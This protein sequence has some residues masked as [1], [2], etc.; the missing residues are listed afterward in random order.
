M[1][2]FIDGIQM[3]QNN[4]ADSLEPALLIVIDSLYINYPE[5]PP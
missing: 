1:N 5:H 2:S 4:S 3:S